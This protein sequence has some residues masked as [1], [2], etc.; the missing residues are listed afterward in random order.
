MMASIWVSLKMHLL[1]I[2]KPIRLSRQ[3]SACK[4]SICSKRVIMHL[5]CSRP[6]P[7]FRKESIHNQ[8]SKI[9]LHQKPYRQA[10]LKTWQR[11][12]LLSR[13]L[14]KLTKSLIVSASWKLRLF[15]LKMKTISLHL[16]LKRARNKILNLRANLFQEARKADQFQLKQLK[17]LLR[18]KIHLNWN[19]MLR[20]ARLHQ[21]WRKQPAENQ[22]QSWR[23]PRAKRILL[24]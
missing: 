3:P 11:S 9:Q 22:H 17:N 12:N 6:R 24:W 8:I 15:F 1:I 4:T 18:L 16:E 10:N 19:I 2:T 14:W 13:K 23:E 5:P 21:I 7:P 20:I